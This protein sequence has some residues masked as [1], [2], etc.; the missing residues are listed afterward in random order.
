MLLLQDAFCC[1]RYPDGMGH[2]TMAKSLFEA[3]A[4]ALHWAEVDCQTFGTAR[5]YRDDQV[6]EIGVGMVP[7]RLVQGSNRARSA[8]DERQPAPFLLGG[9]DRS[10]LLAKPLLD[11]FFDL[12]QELDLANAPSLPQPRPLNVTSAA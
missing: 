1:I 6:L 11:G 5:R 12:F 10:P 8:L 9:G 7:D 4:K 2:N 3:A